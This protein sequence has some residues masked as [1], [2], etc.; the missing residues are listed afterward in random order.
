M[1]RSRQTDL[2][3]LG[4]LS[5][6]PMSGYAVREAIRDVLGQFWSESF[7][8]I[9]PALTR[10]EAEGHVERLAGE[11]KGSFRY[12]LTAAGRERLHALLATPVETAPPRNGLLLRLFF[13]HELGAQASA[14]LVREHRDRA[15]AALDSLALARAEVEAEA[16]SEADSGAESGAGHR[17]YALL[18]ISAGEHSARAALAWAEQA[19][20]ELE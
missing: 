8:Q 11:R 4:A 19:L 14:A 3:V 7:G 18:V 16:E 10:L 9:Y 13:G 6:A 1:A 15:L 12:A 20:A 5:V 2:A 17:R